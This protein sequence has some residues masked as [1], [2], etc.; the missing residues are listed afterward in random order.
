MLAAATGMGELY[1]DNGNG[2]LAPA[3]RVL[4]DGQAGVQLLTYVQS[5]INDGLAVY[6]GDNAGGADQL[7][8]LADQS[9]PA[10]MALGTSAFLTTVINTLAGGLVPGLGPEDV[11]VG[12]M[13]GPVA[14]PTALVG[15]AAIYVTEGKSDL[16]AAAAWDFMLISFWVSSSVSL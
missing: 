10:A 2:R 7:L 14:P 4:Y 16:E 5:L 9:A 1:A 13:P 6:V 3:T 11:G 15:G 8:K 12:A